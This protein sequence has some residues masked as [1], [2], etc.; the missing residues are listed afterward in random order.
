[1]I[2]KCNAL[3]THNRVFHT[4]KGF[5]R[6]FKS[7]FGAS[8]GINIELLE[9][10]FFETEKTKGYLK[11]LSSHSLLSPLDNQ[12][13][14]RVKIKKKITFLSVAKNILMDLALLVRFSYLISVPPQEKCLSRVV[15][16]KNLSRQHLPPAIP[17]ESY[18]SFLASSK[19]DLIN[20]ETLVLIENKVTDLSESQLGRIFL[21][22]D[23][24][25]AIFTNLLIQKDA[26]QLLFRFRKVLP[27]ALVYVLLTKKSK[28]AN[29]ILEIL[30]IRYIEEKG[31]ECI[32]LDSQGSWLDEPVIFFKDSS[33]TN[34]KTV[35]LHYSENSHMY[36]AIQLKDSE[37]LPKFHNVVVDEHWVWTPE[38]ADF[39][40]KLSKSNKFIPKGPLIYRSLDDKDLPFISEEKNAAQFVVTIFDDAPTIDNEWIHHSSLESGLAFLKTIESLMILLHQE[41]IDAVFR[42]KQKRRRIESH[43]RGYFSELQ[44]LERYSNFQILDWDE[45]IIELVLN[46]D[47]VI[48]TLGTSPA[49]VA[50]RLG[51]S[52]C[53]LYAGPAI[54]GTPYVSYGIPTFS[55]AEDVFESVFREVSNAQPHVSLDAQ[56]ELIFKKLPTNRLDN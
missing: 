9:D 28:L 51:V 30:L 40:N 36:S 13:S 48:C 55:S 47:A 27:M 54:L 26:R 56:P 24:R 11:S 50:K 39:Y 46:S 2:A 4:T 33:H 10:R 35:M 7:S 37:L 19:I 45:N 42:I 15:I 41:R 3:I 49:L 22:T 31:L 18:L 6:R 1:M 34:C 43:Q 17:L 21:D 52:V 32:V 8:I 44:K 38:Y 25:K 53:Y 14:M 20:E 23:I 12:I 16:M 5:T 29:S